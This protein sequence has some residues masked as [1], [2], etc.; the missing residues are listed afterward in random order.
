M[1][2]DS[3]ENNLD[4]FDHQMIQPATNSLGQILTDDFGFAKFSDALKASGNDDDDDDDDS[5]DSSIHLK[6]RSFLSWNCT[7]YKN[8][9]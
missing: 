3:F 6:S 8:L 2:A 7:N 1:V 9:G 4:T 5:N